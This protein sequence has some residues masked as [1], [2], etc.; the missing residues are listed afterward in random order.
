MTSVVDPVSI[1]ANGVHPNGVSDI[2][3]EL[4]GGSGSLRFSSGLILPPPEIKC[5][6][7]PYSV[8]AHMCLTSFFVT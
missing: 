2:Q 1:V 4:S 7:N 6:P 5:K 3:L 8:A